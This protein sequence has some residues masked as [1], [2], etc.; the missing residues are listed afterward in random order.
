MARVL[1][2]A[3]VS[4]AAA[5]LGALA[6]PNA[7]GLVALALAILWITWGAIWMD[8]RARVAAKAEAER[9]SLER[10]RSTAS[11]PAEAEDFLATLNAT[12]E[13]PAEVRTEIRDEL[14]AHIEDSI[15]ALETE[16]LDRDRATREALARLGRPEELARQI[17]AAHQ[18]TRRLLAG[19]GGGIFAAGTGVIEGY[20][21]GILIFLM[22]VFAVGGIL[23]AANLLGNSLLHQ[24]FSM[25]SVP[26]A[27]AGGAMLAW[28]PAFVAGRRAARASARASQRTVRQTGTFWAIA[29]FAVIGYVVMF[30]VT[31][32]QDWVVAV[33][34]MAIPVS[35]A[36]GAVL[37]TESEWP[38]LGGWT[39]F[40]MLWMVVVLPALGLVA[41]T[42]SVSTTSG[43]GSWQDPGT[44]A[45]SYDRVA[46]AW[47]SLLVDGNDRTVYEPT[48]D[49]TWH[50]SHPSALAAFSGLR[51]EVWR[52][53]RFPEAPEWAF[54]DVPDP[55]YSAPVATQA[56][57]PSETLVSHFDMSHSKWT[58]W[59]V[60]L[61]GVAS[62][63]IR[64]RM[65]PPLSTP[66]VF[67]GAVWDWISAGN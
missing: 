51:F 61:T 28:V 67:S 22:A 11:L 31:A 23:A 26:S 16:G 63:G 7:R 39:R 1:L 8:R 38:R 64:Y 59:L 50:V 49:L 54:V 32:L 27:S 5:V 57:S 25:I 35:F 14:S 18:T 47:P 24:Q 58:Q 42:W 55:G 21:F 37:K 41:G 66:T 4:V 60:F 53:T 36:A 20:V 46:P 10:S 2:L 52:A 33:A 12:L 6:L 56:T 65:A 34:E 3:A 62:D 29:G 17:R 19:A 44:E 9:R 43:G 48:I 40:A 15:S 45:A 13:L 30:R